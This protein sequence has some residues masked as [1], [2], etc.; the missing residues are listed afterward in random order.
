MSLHLVADAEGTT[1]FISQMTVR[2][3]KKTDI[4][5]TA[6]ACPDAH[7]LSRIFQEFH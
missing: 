5:V 4:G 1:G 2:V 7:F 3:Q 6:I